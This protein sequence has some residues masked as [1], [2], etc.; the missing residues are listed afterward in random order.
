MST[1]CQ[2]E[3]AVFAPFLRELL[4]QST[5]PDPSLLLLVMF[6]KV[7]NILKRQASREI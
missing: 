4:L 1:K 6:E 7:K 3:I 2:L 5:F